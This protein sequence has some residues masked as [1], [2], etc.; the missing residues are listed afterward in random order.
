[1]VNTM[2]RRFEQRSVLVTGGLGGIGLATAQ[3]LA[4]SWGGDI[5][6]RP[7]PRGACFEISV[8]AK[9]S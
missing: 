8:P 2:S 6:Y 5:A 7:R 3:R 4:R 9:E 1:M